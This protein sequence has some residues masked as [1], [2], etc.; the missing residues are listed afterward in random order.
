[1]LFYHCN[2]QNKN[3]ENLPFTEQ[4]IVIV[5]CP[6]IYLWHLCLSNERCFQFLGTAL[7]KILNITIDYLCCRIKKPCL[8]YLK[9]NIILYLQLKKI[10][11][12]ISK[13]QT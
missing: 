3:I 4:N 1:M 6:T 2:K 5:F 12:N 10:Y 7:C 9:F 13:V 11:K 8:Q